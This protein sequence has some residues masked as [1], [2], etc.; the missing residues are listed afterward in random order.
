MKL[1]SVIG[2]APIRLRWKDGVRGLLCIH[3]RKQIPSTN[4]QIPKNLQSPSSKTSVPHAATID[5]LWL[6]FLWSLE[7]G[8][9]S[10]PLRFARLVSE[11]RSQRRD[12][13][14]ESGSNKVL[15]HGLNVFVSGGR[16]FVE[17]VAIFADDAATERRLSEFA[18]AEPF[19]HPLPRIAARPFAT[20]TVS[21]RPRVAF[22]ITSRLHEIA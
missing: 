21:E 22:A 2:L 10:L 15:N 12:D 6:V 13:G 4:I 16:F 18:H 8:I 19:A 5:V 14:H 1:A 11:E 17:Q 20:R 7:L 9:W 3:G